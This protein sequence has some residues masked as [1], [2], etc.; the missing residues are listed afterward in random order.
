MKL[1]ST[2]II[3]LIC[4]VF[5]SVTAPINAQGVTLPI[6]PQ[7]TPY[8]VFNDLMKQSAPLVAYI[9]QWGS[10]G[11]YWNYRLNLIGGNDHQYPYSLDTNIYACAQISL[12]PGIDDA[13]LGQTFTLK[14]SGVGTV[15]VQQGSL[16]VTWTNGTGGTFVLQSLTQLLKVYIQYWSYD[17]NSNRSSL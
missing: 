12:Y 14:Y 5:S 17:T 6:L 16:N 8:R 15:G 11:R 10:V 1:L 4:S 2:L 13:L 3:L 7:P 9:L